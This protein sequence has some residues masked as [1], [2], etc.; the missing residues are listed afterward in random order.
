MTEDA[1]A[2]PNNASAAPGN[3]QG[4]ALDEST[5]LY[6]LESMGIQCWQ[7]LQSTQQTAGHAAIAAAPLPDDDTVEPGT[8]AVD[9]SS[10]ENSILHCTS[11]QLHT[12][13]KQALVGR[14]N[15]AAELMF[16]LL[17]PEGPDEE[18]GMICSGEAEALFTRMLAAID[19]D[20]N[21]V[22]ITS[23]IK[24]RPPR[25][26]T[27]SPREIMCCNEHLKHQVDLVRPAHIIVLGETAIQCLLQKPQPID[28]IRA[29]INSA[30][31][32]SASTNPLGS[33][34]LFVSHSP[35]EL[36]QDAELKRNAWADLQQ[37]Q[38]LIQH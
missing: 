17:A 34:P 28:R 5:R 31:P 1:T 8:E 10:L 33:I 25:N 36:L 2:V 16:I 6:Y 11:C 9:W 29:D 32:A 7:S 12:T 37:L 38:K 23:L 26:H 3:N 19:I 22:Y 13:R 4:C 24:C 14:G 35:H 27:I 20:I 21:D 15:Q 18:A 30:S